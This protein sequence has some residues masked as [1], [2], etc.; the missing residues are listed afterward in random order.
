[1]DAVARGPNSTSINDNPKLAKLVEEL[2]KLDRETAG[3]D[4]TGGA[5]TRH[6]LR[7]AKLLET[8]IAEVKPTERD[9]WIRQLA[10]SFSTAAQS[11][12]EGADALG[13][14]REVQQQ[15]VS[16]MPGSNLT[17]YVTFREM[18]A[19]YAR[20]ITEGDFAKV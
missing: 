7:R 12:K 15:L 2:T 6:H 10:D 13:Y 1:Q 19:D 3:S 4:L 11:S 9:P 16:Q 17:A 14:L 20:K 5:A 8:I 18:Q